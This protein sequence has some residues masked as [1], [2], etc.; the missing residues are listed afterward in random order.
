MYFKE[1]LQVNGFRFEHFLIY[2]FNK[3]QYYDFDKDYLED[4]LLADFKFDFSL[5]ND[6]L[7]S[8]LFFKRIEDVI[9]DYVDNHIVIEVYLCF[10]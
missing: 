9:I 1:F 6:C 7:I 8:K 3:F 2:D 10:G 4:C 5:T